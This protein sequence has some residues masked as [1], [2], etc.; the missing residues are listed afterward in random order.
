[1]RRAIDLTPITLLLLEGEFVKLRLLKYDST[2]KQYVKSWDVYLDDTQE[3]FFQDEDVDISIYPCAYILGPDGKYVPARPLFFIADIDKP[4]DIQRYEQRLSKHL[5]AEPFW[6]AETS[7]NHYSIAYL[8][9]PYPEE[10]YPSFEAIQK[11]YSNIRYFLTSDQ[12]MKEI[13]KNSFNYSFPMRLCLPNTYNYKRNC[14]IKVDLRRPDHAIRKS[15]DLWQWQ[16]PRQQRLQ[17]R[18]LSSEERFLEFFKKF[19]PERIG[20]PHTC[21]GGRALRYYMVNCV[22]CDTPD[23]KPSASIY[24]YPESTIY[25]DYHNGKVYSYRQF[26][27]AFERGQYF[28]M[29]TEEQKEEFFKIKKEISVQKMTKPKQKQKKADD[30]EVLDFL[31]DVLS[32]KASV[33]T[34]HED[35]LTV[36]EEEQDELMAELDTYTFAHAIPEFR[37]FQPYVH[38]FIKLLN[39]QNIEVVFTGRDY[40]LY[41]ELEPKPTAIQREYAETPIIT[42][43]SI[44]FMKVKK[45]MEALQTNIAIALPSHLVLLEVFGK[46]K[47]ETDVLE[48]VWL[49]VVEYLKN[50]FGFTQKL[51]KKHTVQ[52][53]KQSIVKEF[54]IYFKSNS[55]KRDAMSLQTF[56]EVV[57]EKYLVDDLPSGLPAFVDGDKVIIPKPL[58]MRYI[59]LKSHIFYSQ[60]VHFVIDMLEQFSGW[61]E[62]DVEGMPCYVIQR[63]FELPEIVLNKQNLTHFIKAYQK[64]EILTLMLPDNWKDLLRLKS[65]K[66]FIQVNNPNLLVELFDSLRLDSFEIRCLDEKSLELM[67]ALL[68]KFHV[69]YRQDHLTLMPEEVDSTLEVFCVR[70][71]PTGLGYALHIEKDK[72]EPVVDTDEDLTF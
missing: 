55:F 63:D 56:M 36:P 59:K 67:K 52:L 61:Q 12:K 6:V 8:F 29:L 20:S 42:I 70:V 25:V 30:E 22:L 13:D 43:P 33:R 41:I 31:K 32:G 23:H 71:L 24:V 28:E 53:F 39:I 72:E 69:Q 18:N 57:R 40:D 50:K 10:E 21:Y 11:A 26:L 3:E 65:G 60:P 17:E 16:I 38:R 37:A 66:T 64:G 4:V 19:F 68:D 34:D 58:L 14:E 48:T 62:E 1:M 35:I 49:F 54:L 7:P 2:K 47:I 51:S 44:Q 45:F 5:N 9:R 46:T 27:E 15:I